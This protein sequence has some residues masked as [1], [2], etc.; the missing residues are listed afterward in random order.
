MTKPTDTPELTSSALKKCR[1]RRRLKKGTY[2]KEFRHLVE[3]WLDWHYYPINH[4]IYAN[5]Y[6][7]AD[8]AKKYIKKQQKKWPNFEYEIIGLGD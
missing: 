6:Q 1:V 3:H 2:S 4:E 5:I 7:S 8:E